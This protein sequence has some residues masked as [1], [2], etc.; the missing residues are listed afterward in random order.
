VARVR[1]TGQAASA[2]A[3]VDEFGIDE[4]SARAY[5]IPAYAPEA[6]GTLSWEQT[7]IVVARARSAGQVGLGYSY[8]AAPAAALIEGVLAGAVTGCDAMSPQAAWE[9]MRAAV[10]NIGYPGLAACAISA[11][12]SAL[13]DLKARLLDVSLSTLLGAVREQVPVYGSGGFTSYTDAQLARQLAGWV[14]EGIDAVKMKVGSEPE[15]DTERVRRAREAIGSG[16]ELYVDANGAYERK[17]AVRLAELFC[18]ES[19]VTWFEEPV[20]S[21]DLEGLRMLRDRV[22]APM[23]IAAGEYGYEPAYFQRMLAA[24]AVDVLQADVTRCGGITQML[25]VGALCAAAAIPMSAHTAPSL[26]AHVC[27]A[28]P[29]VENVEYFHDHARI[30]AMLFDGLPELVDGAL[31]PDPNRPGSGLELR[32]SDAERYQV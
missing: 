1:I 27:A 14:R 17:Q 28:I 13:W 31:R 32:E 26:H 9:S 5:T 22:P 20:S 3:A 19:G 8:T 6:D 29:A 10:R 25:Q 4:V 16:A 30:E 18:E 11:V 15:R 12:D 21:D 24:G 2:R 7:T 23:R